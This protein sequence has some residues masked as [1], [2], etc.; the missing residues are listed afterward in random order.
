MYA[1]YNT[2][3]IIAKLPIFVKGKMCLNSPN[4]LNKVTL[5]CIKFQTYPRR[6]F[7]PRRRI[8][9]PQAAQCFTLGL[10]RK[11]MTECEKNIHFG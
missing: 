2:E 9:N 6:L 4:S 10:M 1:L 5:L 3:I 7:Y 8:G 11:L